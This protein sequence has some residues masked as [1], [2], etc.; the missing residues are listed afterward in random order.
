MQ[1]SLSSGLA[2]W[3]HLIPHPTWSFQMGA[4]HL[5]LSTT[6]K[7]ISPKS[8]QSNIGNPHGREGPSFKET[9]FLCL[10]MLLRGIDP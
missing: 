9:D 4:F 3:D 2:L 7:L 1:S 5:N 6:E 8:T 10:W